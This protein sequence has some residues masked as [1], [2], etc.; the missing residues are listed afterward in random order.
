MRETIRFGEGVSTLGDFLVA[1]SA[2]GVVALEFANESGSL[3]QELRN[4]FTDAEIR[5]ET[6]ELA[7]L[8]EKTA[9]LIE[10]PAMSTDL[11]ADLRGS[12]FQCQV[13]KQLQLIP[14]GRTTTYQVVAY[15]LRLPVTGLE[16]A[17]AC[18]ASTIAMLVPTHRI[19]NEDGTASGYRWGM[20]RQLALLGRERLATWRSINP[21]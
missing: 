8:I 21:A 18:G 16:V 11:V 15:R 4:R 14:P 2:R 9:A 6:S 3:T 5:G 7:P 12:P 17:M 10:D 20:T 13:W 19:V 1:V